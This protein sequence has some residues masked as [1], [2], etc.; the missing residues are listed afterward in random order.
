[1]KITIHSRA[2]VGVI[3][4]LTAATADARTWT[5]TKGRTIEADFVKMDGDKVVVKRSN[6]KTVSIALNLLSQA[7]KDFIEQ[8]SK[9]APSLDGKQSA[10]E[11][12]WENYGDPWPDTVTAPDFDVEEVKEEKG[13]Y[14]Y[15]TPHFRFICDAKI[16]T[17][18]VKQLARMFEATH[19]AN[20]TL[21][22]GNKPAHDITAKFPAYLYES[23]ETYRAKGGSEGS[24]GIFIGSSRPNDPGKVLVPFRS[25]GVKKTGSTYVMDRKQEP[26]TL[27]HEITHQM[28]SFSAKRAGWFCEGSAEYMANTP[29]SNAGTFRFSSNKKSIVEKVTAF[30]KK[31]TGGRGLGK[32]IKAPNLEKYMNMPYE[33]FTTVNPQMNYGLAALMAYYFYH[34]DGEGD[35]KRIKEYVKAVQRGTAEREA[36]KLLLDGRTYDELAKDIEKAWRSSGVK[37]EFDKS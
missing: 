11:N 2:L 34:M 25:L 8:Q 16:G 12:D 9:A 33:Q 21:P 31:G 7:D 13:E 35:A 24:A 27:I 4:A 29:Y 23:Y 10:G 18:C 6:G 3:L 5:D 17:N 15:E 26:T 36:Q 28:M 32:D 14:I 30:G 19:L 37:L 22:L 20:K 1:M